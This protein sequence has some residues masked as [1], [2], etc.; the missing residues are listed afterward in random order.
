MS[1]TVIKCQEKFDSSREPVYEI[2]LEV[3]S[4]LKLSSFK[5][6]KIYF[7]DVT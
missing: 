1:R 2:I 4:V 6:N 3:V 5:W 7:K